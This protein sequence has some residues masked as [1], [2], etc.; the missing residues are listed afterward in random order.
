M[1]LF[2]PKYD[3][4]ALEQ[5][6]RAAYASR[7]RGVLKVLSIETGIPQQT[8]SLFAVRKLG[9]PMLQSSH[10]CPKW[11]PQEDDVIVR[12][13]H[14]PS[15]AISARLRKVG[16]RRG[17]KA[18]ANRRCVLRNQGREIGAYRLHYT[19]DEICVA[20]GVSAPVV[21]R[22]SKGGLLAAKAPAHIRNGHGYEIPPAAL[23]EFL[24]SY[25]GH[26]CKTKPDLV[27]LTDVLANSKADRADSK[28]SKSVAEVIP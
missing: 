16:C 15:S 25:T 10:R 11:T 5:K 27:W 17:Q 7:R 20:M 14:E 6:V 12:W 4:L 18:I 24:I 13:S 26:W 9:L 21:M 28:P 23:R 1:S 8:L 2:Q 3:W 22:W 19:V